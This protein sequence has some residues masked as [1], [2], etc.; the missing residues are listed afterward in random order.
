[1]KLRNL[2]FPL[3]SI[4]LIA[5]FVACSSD[6]DDDDDL[7]GTWSWQKDVYEVTSNNA[8]FSKALSDYL[9]EEGDGNDVIEFKSD[10]TFIQRYVDIE[11]GEEFTVTIP[12]SYK[13]SDGVLSTTVGGKNYTSNVQINGNILSFMEDETSDYNAAEDIAWYVNLLGL[14]DIDPTTVKIDKVLYKSVYSR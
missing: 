6:D 3:F 12:G 13:Y 1:M 5:G 2:L 9:S 7:V 11:D 8:T 10:G 14:V 4:V